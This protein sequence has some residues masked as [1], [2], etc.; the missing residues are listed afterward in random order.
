MTVSNHK[1]NNMNVKKV[2]VNQ[3]TFNQIAPRINFQPSEMHCD[4]KKRQGILVIHIKHIKYS[5]NQKNKSTNVKKSTLNHEI[6]NPAYL[7]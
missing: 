3:E 6:S 2:T 1:Y 5:S 7:F 4:S